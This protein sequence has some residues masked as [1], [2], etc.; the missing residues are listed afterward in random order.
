MQLYI[1]LIFLT[2]NI[3]LLIFCKK[4]SLLKDTAIDQHKKF[5]KSENS[6]LIG[7]LVILTYFIYYFINNKNYII[8]TFLISFFIIGFLSDIRILNNPKVRFWLQTIIIL[9]FI[10]IIDLKITESRNYFFNYLLINNYFNNLFVVF[11]LM[12]LVNGSNFIDGLNT[13]LSNYYISV[14]SIIIIFFELSSADFFLIQNLIIVLTSIILFNVFS[15]IFVGDSGSYLISLFAGIFLIQFAE[16]RTDISPYFIILLLWYPCF[17]LLF[18]M[19]RRALSK[20]KSYEPDNI[21]LHQIIYSFIKQKLN[22][23]NIYAQLLSSMIINFFN[24]STFLFAVNFSAHTISLL[25][26]IILNIT[27]YMTAYYILASK[28]NLSEF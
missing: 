28:L 5:T 22:I 14:F 12:V 20:M 19:I 11:C 24:F 7:G 17:E 15:Y 1:F 9:I 18:S 25:L 23:K 16:T 8:L 26:I 4:Y 10:N 2:L 3:S 21:H 6:Y 13:L 27:I